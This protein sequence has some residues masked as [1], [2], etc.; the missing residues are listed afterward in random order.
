MNLFIAFVLYF[1]GSLLAWWCMHC[2]SPYE[3][4]ASCGGSAGCMALFVFDTLCNP[5][6]AKNLSWFGMGTV[7]MK[8]WQALLVHT[9]LHLG[10]ELLPASG[11][12]IL[13]YVC[14]MRH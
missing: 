8:T 10:P 14:W 6:G 1:G 12:G 3:M 5:S 4:R 9:I 11:W 7:P 13:L 2:W